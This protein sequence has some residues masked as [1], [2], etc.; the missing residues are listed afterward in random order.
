MAKFLLSVYECSACCCCLILAAYLFLLSLEKHL[1]DPIIESFDQSDSEN[2]RTIVQNV[3]T[4]KIK[5]HQATT[6]G[7]RQNQE[8]GSKGRDTMWEQPHSSS[9]SNEFKPHTG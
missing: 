8:I 7:K 5:R 1:S 2:D 9:C 4:E 6:Q 3:Q